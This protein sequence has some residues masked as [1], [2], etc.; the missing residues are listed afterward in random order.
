MERTYISGVIGL[1]VIAFAIFAVGSLFETAGYMALISAIVLAG[2]LFALL[3]HVYFNQ[4]SKKEEIHL[5][6]PTEETE[7]EVITEGSGAE[8]FTPSAASSGPRFARP[9]RGRR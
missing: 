6:S 1:V 5:L 8:Q 4:M 3:L 7:S 2:V 9:L